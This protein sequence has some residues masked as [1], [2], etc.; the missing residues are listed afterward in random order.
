MLRASIVS[1][2]NLK[3]IKYLMNDAIPSS[4]FAQ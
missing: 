4:D 1:L 2:L 3:N